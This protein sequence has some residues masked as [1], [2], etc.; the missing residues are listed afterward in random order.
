MK[1]KVYMIVIFIT[2]SILV[3]C[4]ATVEET[5]EVKVSENKRFNTEQYEE[6]DTIEDISIMTDSDTG[7]EYIVRNGS[8]FAS[9]IT[10]LLDE[11]GNPSGCYSVE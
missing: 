9:G 7:C 1:I 8:K 6:L 11:Y 5:E 3:A 10:A 2:F 4:S